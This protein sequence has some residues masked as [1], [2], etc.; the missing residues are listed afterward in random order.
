M[1]IVLLGP[2]GA[3]KGT[4]ADRLASALDLPH[5]A[6]GDLFREHLRQNTALGQQAREYMDKGELVPDDITIAMI[7]DRL[8]RTDYR[9]SVIL[10]GFPR[11]LVQ[12]KGLDKALSDLR[13]ELDV[14]LNISVP[15]DEVVRRLSGRRICRECQTPY[16]VDF[17]P[18]EREGVCDVC[19]GELYQREDDRPETVKKRLQ[20]YHRQTEPLID[21]YRQAGLLKVVDGD[22]GIEPVTRALL[23]AIPGRRS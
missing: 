7:R 22:Q 8:G 12:A 14:V 10:D 18:P 4:Q 9:E 11:T 20:V 5:L 23:E 21:Y 2:P 17:N 1:E 15:E 16:H 13:R 6:S 19:G 3:G